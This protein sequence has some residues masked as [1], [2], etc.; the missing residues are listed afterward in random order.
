MTL[1]ELKTLLALNGQQRIMY[2]E[3]EIFGNIELTDAYLKSLCYNVHIKNRFRWRPNNNIRSIA[4]LA[5]WYAAH[6]IK[7]RWL[8]AE[9]LIKT[10]R[11]ARNYYMGDVIQYMEDF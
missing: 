5:Y 11:N 2:A 6:V 1:N 7:G 9:P 3:N 10:D 4:W 8:E